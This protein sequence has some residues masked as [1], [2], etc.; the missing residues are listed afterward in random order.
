M[1]RK[2]SDVRDAL[3]SDMETDQQAR[4]LARVAAAHVAPKAMEMEKKLEDAFRRIPQAD[5]LRGESKAARKSA[6]DL[7]DAVEQEFTNGKKQ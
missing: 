7:L 6:R 3:N 5:R 1:A 2:L 4:K